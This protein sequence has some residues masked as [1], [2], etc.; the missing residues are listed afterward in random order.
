MGLG[1]GEGSRFVVAREARVGGG[2]CYEPCAPQSSGQTY[3]STV[4][5]SMLHHW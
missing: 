1:E 2:C 5:Q 4:P 3:T